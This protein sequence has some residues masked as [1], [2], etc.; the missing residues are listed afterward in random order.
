MAAT[1]RTG[2]F[3]PAVDRPLERPGRPVKQRPHL[4]E[5]VIDHRLARRAP[6]R[7]QHLPHPHARQLRIIRQQSM[8][9][10]LERL[11][12]ALPRRSLIPRWRLTAQRPPNRVLR[13]PRLTHQPL[14]RLSRR[15][16]ARA[17][18]TPT[19]PHQPPSR[20]LS[21][22]NTT[23]VDS[24]PDDPADPPRG[25]VFKRRRGVSFHPAPTPGSQTGQTR[26]GAGRARRYV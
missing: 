2:R 17:A 6:Q 12:H 14:D 8:D 21:S 24:T 10:R 23:S 20:R 4:S 1:R 18:T 22:L 16:N 9:L 5:V 11:Q 26:I 7:Q 25:S 13:E 15:R 3:P 19:A